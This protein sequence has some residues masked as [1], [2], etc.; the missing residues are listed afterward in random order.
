MDKRTHRQ[1]TLAPPYISLLLIPGP[2]S[3]RLVAKYNT[4]K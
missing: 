1:G 4:E 3:H 2:S